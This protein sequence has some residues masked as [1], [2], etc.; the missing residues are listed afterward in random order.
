MSE[1]RRAR[2]ATKAYAAAMAA[3]QQ[4]R[5]GYTELLT[6]ARDFDGNASS[7]LMLKSG[8]AVFYEVNGTALIEDRRGP[9]QYRR[10]APKVCCPGFGV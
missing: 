4:E 1:D 3:W 2:K 6:V 10:A 9:G 8:E 5:D 7:G